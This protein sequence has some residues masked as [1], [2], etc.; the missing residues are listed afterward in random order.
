MFV[1]TS[2]SS[3]SHIIAIP[4]IN[5]KS[6]LPIYISSDNGVNW[7]TSSLSS[8]SNGWATA[9]VSNTGQFMAVASG[10]SNSPTYST[11]YISNNYGLNWKLASGMP[12]IYNG[13]WSVSFSGTGEYVYAIS[14]YGNANIW[15][16]KDYG[17]TWSSILATASN[18][19]Y[20]GLVVSSS[21]QYITAI[22]SDTLYQS[23]D[24]GSTWA[25]R[26]PN[27][28]NCGSI[29]SLASS[30][31][32]T[33]MIVM[34]LCGTT[35]YVYSSSDYGV[36]WSSIST[37][38]LSN[39]CPAISLTISTTGQFIAAS[40]QGNG[41]YVSTD[42]GA[43]W[44]LENSIPSTPCSSYSVSMVGNTLVVGTTT[45]SVYLGSSSFMEIKLMGKKNLRD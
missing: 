41:I 38:S 39:P 42:Y 8:P 26:S 5:D 40:F 14:I 25:V 34:S 43:S 37:V 15:S 3:S 27:F 20:S 22:N 28:Q 18:S 32:C 6:G 21:G 7:L 45:G 11:L 33:Y 17:V 9:K 36:T 4:V 10:G 30:V 29:F 1:S 19:L 13:Y 2:R 23:A 16:S 12:A 31:D 24:Y 44:I 35:T